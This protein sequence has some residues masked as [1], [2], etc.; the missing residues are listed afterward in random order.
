MYNPLPT[1]RTN[2][3]MGQALEGVFLGMTDLCKVLLEEELEA[4]DF[5]VVVD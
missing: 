2:G 5:L 4:G 3:G 1:L